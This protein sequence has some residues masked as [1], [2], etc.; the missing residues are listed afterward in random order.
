MEQI[1]LI[2]FQKHRVW[3]SYTYR[4]RWGVSGANGCPGCASNPGY[5]VEK[6]HWFGVERK[7][8]YFLYAGISFLMAAA[9]TVW[10]CE[11]S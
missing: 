7:K 10:I 3:F 1:I 6:Y 9:S 8:T 2:C 5:N 4:A 11:G